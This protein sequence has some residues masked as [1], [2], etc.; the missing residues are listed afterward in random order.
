MI[1]AGTNE[2]R[3]G[4]GGA[5]KGRE[6]GAQ[7][8]GQGG[9]ISGVSHVKG[10]AGGGL[11]RIRGSGKREDGRR[12]RGG[13]RGDCPGGR[14]AFGCKCREG[15]MESILGMWTGDAWKCGSAEVPKCESVD[16]FRHCG[17]ADSSPRESVQWGRFQR[18]ARD[19]SAGA[20]ER[21]RIEMGNPHR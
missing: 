14:Y 1:G 7:Q 17:C 12:K 5:G 20:W 16:A 11:M 18:A 10:E 3:G 4:M 21:I 9:P 13:K 15:G 6:E 19:E 8:S 2:W